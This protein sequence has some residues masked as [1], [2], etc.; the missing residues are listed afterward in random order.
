M[1]GETTT[2]TDIHSSGDVSAAAC[3][4][5][6]HALATAMPPPDAAFVREHRL[7]DNAPAGARLL[8]ID[9]AVPRHR[10]LRCDEYLFV[11]SGAASFRI[12]GNSSLVLSPGIFVHFE[13]GVWHEIS[14]P[15]DGPLIV[16]AFETPRR[17]PLDVEFADL[18]EKPLLQAR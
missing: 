15:S 17:D 6:L 8:R 14:A 13:R 11:V 7:V 2:V 4:F 3:I 18:S 5:E 10:H 16:L 1:G 12:G 9:G